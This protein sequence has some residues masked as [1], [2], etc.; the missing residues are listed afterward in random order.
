MRSG[1]WAFPSSPHF[2][3]SDAAW[4]WA[5]DELSARFRRLYSGQEPPL[6]IGFLPGLLGLAHRIEHRRFGFSTEKIGDEIEAG[7]DELSDWAAARGPGFFLKPDAAILRRWAKSV[8]G[9][10]ARSMSLLPSTRSSKSRTI[11]SW[12]THW[13]TV[14]P[15]SPTK[16]PRPRRRRSRSQCVHWHWHQVYDAVRDAPP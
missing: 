2:W 16:S 14:T 15:S 8:L 6:R 4:G 11:T 10:R 13:L 3:N 1:C 5:S 7:A 9:R 12:G